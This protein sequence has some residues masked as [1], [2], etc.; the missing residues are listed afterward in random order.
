MGSGTK[1][2]S[3]SIDTCFLFQKHS[4]QVV[5]FTAHL[6]LLL[7]SGISGVVLLLL[8]YAFKSLA[9]TPLSFKLRNTISNLIL[10]R[11]KFI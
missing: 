2:A 4:G 1:E 5:G 7:R 8:L 10:L 3:S 6:H 9:G 11:I